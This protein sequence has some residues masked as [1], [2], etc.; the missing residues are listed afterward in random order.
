MDAKITMEE[1]TGLFGDHIPMDVVVLLDR[2]PAGENTIGDLRAILNERAIRYHEDKLSY[3]RVSSR[4][5]YYETQ[6]NISEQRRT[7]VC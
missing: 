4:A 1:V 7:Q 2:W 5:S 6:F 3:D